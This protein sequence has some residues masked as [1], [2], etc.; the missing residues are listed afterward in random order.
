[1][2]E[3]ESKL[4]F[5]DPQSSVGLRTKVHHLD[6]GYTCVQKMR[7][8]TEDPKKDIWGKS[9]FFGLGGVLETSYHY[10]TL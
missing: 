4:S 8:F 1:M 3:R 5:D 2:R 10:T 7:D 6:E 9:K